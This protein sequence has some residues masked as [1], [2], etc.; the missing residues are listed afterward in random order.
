MENMEFLKTMLAEMNAKKN[1]KMDVTQEKMDAN[2]KAVQE[3]M[4][5]MKDEN[6]KDMNANR[7][8]DPGNLKEMMEE[9]MNTN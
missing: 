9:M 8:A 3:R 4:N 6:K 7:K 5:E 2:N 1:A